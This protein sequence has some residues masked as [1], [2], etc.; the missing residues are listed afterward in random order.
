MRFMRR[1]LLAALLLSA[2]RAAAQ[3]SAP[4]TAPPPPVS[5]GTYDLSAVEVPPRITNRAQAARAAEEA[6]GKVLGPEGGRGSLTLRFVVNRDGTTS[7]AAVVPSTGNP[8]LDE[9]ALTA[10]RAMRFTPAKI[11]RRTVPVLVQLP[12][13]Y[14]APPRKAEGAPAPDPSNR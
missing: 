11:N 13:S 7:R 4:P 3:E 2:G 5:E 14:D 9:A 10:L 1:A 12:L 6:F 8:G